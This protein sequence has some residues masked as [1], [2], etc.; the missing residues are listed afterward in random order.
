[1]VDLVLQQSGG[2]A[3]CSEDVFPVVQAQIPD[4]YIIGACPTLDRFIGLVI[5]FRL[6]PE[7]MSGLLW[8]QLEGG[9]QPWSNHWKVFGL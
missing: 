2:R 5:G 4:L 8:T 9:K 3:L 1:M 6:D 7:F